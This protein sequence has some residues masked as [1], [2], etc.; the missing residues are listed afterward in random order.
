L[1]PWL[2]YDAT[3]SRLFEQITRLPE[4][5]LTRCER[6]ILAR[7]AR[8][9]IERAGSNLSLVELGAGTAA[10]TG[11]IIRAL[12]RRQLRVEFY[13]VDV[14][15]SALQVARQSLTAISDR[16]KVHPIV[17]DYTQGLDGVAQ[18]RG[19]KLAL[20]LGSS[21]G[22][23]EPEAATV[24]LQTLRA[25]LRSGDALLLGTDL[26]KSESLLLPA[27]DDS[28]GVT[29]RF[30]KNL[31]V[32]INRE[33]DGQFDLHAFHHRAR[34][35]DKCSR[36]EMHLE[37]GKEQTVAIDRLGLQIPFRT[38]ESIHTENSYK[39]TTE[40]V[41]SILHRSGF[42]PEH[43]W[44]DRCGYFAVHLARAI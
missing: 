40:S 4:Y 35:N 23:F 36:M 22:N 16:V 41:H 21:I 30:N 39:H 20:Y 3:G 43:T 1:P 37:S 29:A 32:R 18:L 38:G 44:M 9:M 24:V 14:C 15:A 17:A 8:E 12:L 5:Y 11:T 19:R 2:F 26:V 34:W 28:A 42:Q 25:H 31:L 27:Y 10:K 13:P 33:L 6:E 7:Y